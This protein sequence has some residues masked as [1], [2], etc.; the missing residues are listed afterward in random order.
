MGLLGRLLDSGH[1]L[2]NSFD[3]LTLHTDVYTDVIN[4]AFDILHVLAQGPFAAAL[5][6][7]I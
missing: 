4:T 6:F 2:R 5:R 7:N 3:P 1:A